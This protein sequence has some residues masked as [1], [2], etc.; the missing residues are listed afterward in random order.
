MVSPDSDGVSRV[1]SYLGYRWDSQCFEQGAVTRYGAP[2]QTPTLAVLRPCPGPATPR[3]KPRGLGYFRFRSPL[4]TE[5]SFLSS[6]PAT[7]MFHFAGYRVR[8]PMDSAMDTI[9]EDGGLPHSEI[10]GSK[11]ACVS[12]EL[13][14]A[15]RVLLRLPPPRH[16]PYARTV[17]TPKSWAPGLHWHSRRTEWGGGGLIYVLTCILLVCWLVVFG[18]NLHYSHGGIQEPPCGRLPKKH[19]GQK[20]D[21]KMVE[22]RTGGRTWTRTMDLVLIRD[23][24]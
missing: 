8:W 12:P 21:W 2:F 9:L 24:L 15:C 20:A 4:L 6:P 18:S 22:K 3:G 14:A 11:T 13:I 19:A 10:S 5:S 1:P 7:E 17:W 16:P 23:A